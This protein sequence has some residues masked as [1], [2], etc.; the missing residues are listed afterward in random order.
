MHTSLM[1]RLFIE[2]DQM[3]TF[4][5]PTADADE[6]R[7]AVR[8]LAHA[9]RAIDDPSAIYS[10]LGAISA[11]LAS[12]SQSLHQLGAFHDGPHRQEAWLSGE[13]RAASYQASWELHRAAEM[14]H[15]VAGCVDRAREI[16]ATIT[17]DGPALAPARRQIR[18]PGLSL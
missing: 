15:Q 17:Y 2:E 16:E 14:I 9:T 1:N 18:E 13:S 4:T 12:M 8:G 3:P 11:S 7:E 10:V 5:N 6:A